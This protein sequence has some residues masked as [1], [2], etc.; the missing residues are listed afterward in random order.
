MRGDQP[1]SASDSGS[2]TR[3]VSMNMP[4]STIGAP[5]TRR[6]PSRHAAQPS[7]AIAEI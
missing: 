2:A 7:S 4:S 6:T 3:S 1:R 5:F